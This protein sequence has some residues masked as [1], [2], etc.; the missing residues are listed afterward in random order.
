MTGLVLPK[1]VYEA[2]RKRKAGLQDQ[3]VADTIAK[4]RVH[5]FDSDDFVTQ[6]DVLFQLFKLQSYV[7]LRRQEQPEYH[8][9]KPVG[10][11]IQV[12]MLTIPEKTAGG[13][14][15]PEDHAEQRA[16]ASPQGVVL[17]M[18]AGCYRDKSRFSIDGEIVPWCAVGDRV[19]L[20]RY[21]AQWF[22]IANGQ[23]LGVVSDTQPVAVIDSGW[24]VPQ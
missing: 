13:L 2:E 8:L 6:E 19:Q 23:R 12:L 4:S 22:Q 18:G 20:V 3:A 14:I 17:A 11:R 10:W 15:A 1:H 16:L 7:E 9:P 5:R 24:E 21:D